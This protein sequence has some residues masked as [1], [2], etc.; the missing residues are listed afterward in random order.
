MEFLVL[1]ILLVIYFIPVIIASGREHP[2]TGAIFI[3]NLLLGWTLL[4]WVFAIVWSFTNPTQVIVSNHNNQS[5]ESTADEIN[6]LAALKKQGLLTEE[7]FAAQ[8]Q[9]L[10]G[11][12]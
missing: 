10:L 11:N 3:L 9:K 7:E 2:S 6:K 5:T 1:I 4:G 8:K 12:V